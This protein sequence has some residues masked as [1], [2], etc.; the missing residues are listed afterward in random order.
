M[1]LLAAGQLWSDL[2]VWGFFLFIQLIALP[3][4]AETIEHWRDSQQR[5]SPGNPTELPG[6]WNILEGVALGACIPLSLFTLYYALLPPVSFDALEYHLG[7]PWA[8]WQEGGMRFLPSLFYSNFPM[9]VE[10]LFT[11]AWRVGG[12]TAIKVFHWQIGLLCASAIFIFLRRRVSRL[13]AL[14][15]ALLFLASPQVIGLSISAKIDLGLTFFTL[16]AFHHFM[17][18]IRKSSRRDLLLCAVF[19]GLAA[20][21]KYSAIGLLAAPLF[22]GVALQLFLSKKSPQIMLRRASLFLLII[23][24]VFLPWAVKNLI[25]QG[26]PVFPLGYGLFGGE[27]MDDSI[28]RF[29]VVSTDATWR[30][31]LAELQNTGL[32]FGWIAGLWHILTQGQILLTAF[33]ILSPWLLLK[34]SRRELRITTLAALPGWLVWWTLSRPLPRY[35][36]LLYPVMIVLIFDYLS[37]LRSRWP[38]RIL[39]VLTAGWAFFCF[40][41]LGALP[42]Q[43]PGAIQY[44]SRSWSREEFLF[45]GLPHFEA[46]AR[47]NMLPRDSSRVLFVAEARGYGCKVPYTLSTVYDSSVL[48]R[49]IQGPPEDWPEQLRKAGFTHL[50]FNE[51]ELNRWRRTFEPFGW[52]EGQTIKESMQRLKKTGRL[53]LLHAT[54]STPAGR[55]EVWEVVG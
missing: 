15:A 51:I 55:V 1:F 38:S 6:R 47:V 32:P 25:Y 40:I 43:M 52:D 53:R 54:K 20:G 42:A 30:E 37:G 5:T 2:Y 3:R 49:I 31:E 24:A 8:W 17:L 36:V 22:V 21:C 10:M 45:R 18:W 12:E 13:G 26:N 50:L 14:L 41:G 48:L 46:I 27:T 7:V 9:Y 16:L 28:H 39:W 29:M 34:S 4:W 33:L 11:L 44:H 23:A 35:L 19:C